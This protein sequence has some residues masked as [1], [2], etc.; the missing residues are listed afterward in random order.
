M[1]IRDIVV[2]GASA[3][4]VEALQ[5]LVRALPKDFPAA[6]FVVLHLWPRASSALPMIL[7]RAGRLPAVH[8]VDNAPVEPGRIYVAPQD[9]HMLLEGGRIRLVRGPR[10]NRHRPAVDPLFRSAALSYGPRVIGVILTGS[11]DDGTAGLYA[12]KRAGGVAVVQDPSDAP[13]AGMPTHA[14]QNVPVDHIVPLAEIPRLLV[15][16]V[17]TSVPPD[18]SQG[19]GEEV[20][21]EV[22]YAEGSRD[23]MNSDDQPGEP[24]EFA[25]PECHG[26]L[27]EIKEGKILR[28]RCRVGH[29]Y[30]AESLSS[31]M[32]DTTENALWVALRA[33]E[34]LASL[35]RKLASRAE[36]QDLPHVIEHHS[37]DAR[38]H[39]RS[40][41]TIRALLMREVTRPEEPERSAG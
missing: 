32:N 28:F 27:W 22:E 7:S 13:Y 37:A 2:V 41:N 24:A 39:E 14:I 34:E 5:R 18:K 21:R 40:A 8:P 30:S 3:G 11:L 23:A 19:N 38:L 31:E 36:L 6:V 4:G 29:A 26:A 9:V 17:G 10:E 12:I 16:L 35:H 33:L 15:Q 20:K 1:P 25:C